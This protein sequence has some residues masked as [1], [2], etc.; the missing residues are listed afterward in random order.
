MRILK[1]ILAAINKYAIISALASL[2]MGV[3]LLFAS[4]AMFRLICVIF[5]L[6]LIIPAVMWIYEGVVRGGGP[7]L[8]VPGV[9]VALTGAFVAF[10]DEDFAALFGGFFGVFL[11]I[12]G[13]VHVGR[14][15]FDRAAGDSGWLLSLILG[16]GVGAFGLVCMAKSGEVTSVLMK[17]YGVAFLIYAVAT[18]ISL[19]EFNKTVDEVKTKYVEPML[20]TINEEAAAARGYADAPDDAPTAVSTDDSVV[21]VD[22]RVIDVIND[23]GDEYAPRFCRCNTANA[24]P[25]Q[26]HKKCRVPEP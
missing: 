13:L 23:A 15:L 25:F 2:G 22:G 10:R 19:W 24:N 17:I 9:I 8:I 16:V 12:A 26:H 20:E 18:L 7:L 5:G 11:L 14:A 1:S 3:L 21:E 4:D 6:M